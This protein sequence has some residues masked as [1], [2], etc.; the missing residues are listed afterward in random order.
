[1][2]QKLLTTLEVNAFDP[3]LSENQKKEDKVKEFFM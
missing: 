2:T 1:M 3:T